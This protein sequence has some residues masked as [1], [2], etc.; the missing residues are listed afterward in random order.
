MRGSRIGGG[1][2][3]QPA[4]FMKLGLIVGMCGDV[5]R[6]GRGRPDA[7][8]PTTP[9]IL[10]AIALIACPLGLIMLQPDLGSAIVLCAAGF[11]V[12]I[13]AG[14]PARWT[15]GL[16]VVGVAGHR[17][18]RQGRRPRRVPAR[19]LP[20]VHAPGR[21]PAGRGLQRQPGAHRHRQRAAVRAPGCS[22]GRRPTA[23]SCP[24]QQTDFVFSVAGEEFGF[25]GSGLII[26]LFGL[27]CWRGLR[28]ARGRRPHRPADRAAASSAGSP[29]RRS[30]TS[31]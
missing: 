12:L 7:E 30:R 6:P 10:I 4:E 29:S 3:L 11:G 15:I 9:D 28:I 18:R 26:A 27:L 24:E 21:R 1:F 16:I 19:S 17:P 20:I 23:R 22:T 8:R 31:A 14:V 2:E 5:R 13:A 25:V